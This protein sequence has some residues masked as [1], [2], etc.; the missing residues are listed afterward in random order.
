M[1]AI[2]I[3]S[4]ASV[5][6]KWFHTEGEAEVEA[7]GAILA[8]HRARAVLV[9]V[10]DL[11]VYEVGNALLRGRARATADQVA[12]VLDALATICPVLRPDLSELRLASDLS[13]RHGLTLY[14]AA[15]AAVAERRAATLVTVDD[16][17]V[18]AGLGQRPSAVAAAL[19][20]GG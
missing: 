2:D 14:D 11:T 4:D 9:G 5:V 13:V 19:A 1:P 12:T 16:A 10:L 3:V 6:L 18:R 8:A 20:R 7:A 17:L 15:Y